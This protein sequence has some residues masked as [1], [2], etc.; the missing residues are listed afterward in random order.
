LQKAG[1]FQ[2]TLTAL[3]YES[4]EKKLGTVRVKMD[5]L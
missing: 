2:K 1:K 5:V 3:C 4:R